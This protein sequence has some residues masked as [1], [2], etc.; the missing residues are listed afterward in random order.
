MVLS[1][2]AN[3]QQRF[4]DVIKWSEQ[5]LT[6]EPG[7]PLAYMNMCS[8]YMQ[9]KQYD[10]AVTTCKKGLV[11]KNQWSAK[12]NFNI[13]LTLFQK[14]VGQSK[15]GE[16]L[17]AEPYFKESQRLDPSIA[18]NDYY[19]GII[20]ENTKSNP[21]AAVPL[22][23]AGCKKGSAPACEAIPRAKAAV[24]AVAV[25]QPAAQP[26]S[27]TEPASQEEEN[28]WSLFESSYRKKGLDAVSAKRNVGAVRKGM[29]KMQPALRV[30]TL[31][32]MLKQMQ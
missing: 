14:A 22:Y 19:L 8:A 28:L 32:S 9:M 21:K 12:L 16:T 27:K 7:L 31:Q 25:T 23:E 11:T 15:F 24:N 20:E 17:S 13:G 5:A 1:V 4:K 30:Q 3:S 10:Q 6:Q 26:V 18:Q 29:S 2:I